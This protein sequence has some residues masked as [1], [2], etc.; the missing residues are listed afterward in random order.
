MDGFASRQSLSLLLPLVRVGA[1]PGTGTSMLWDTVTRQSL[2]MW[3]RANTCQCGSVRLFANWAHPLT[4]T[5]LK[6]GLAFPTIS[7]TYLFP[8]DPVNIY[9]KFKFIFSWLIPSFR[10]L[11]W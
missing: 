10:A 8:P 5:V 4:A 9:A 3:V 7:G 2:I 1:S 11:S 6:P